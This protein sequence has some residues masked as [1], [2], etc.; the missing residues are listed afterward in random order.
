MTGSSLVGNQRLV[1]ITYQGYCDFGYLI[2]GIEEVN[3]LPM[4]RIEF[5]DTVQSYFP[6]SY[7]PKILHELGIDDFTCVPLKKIAIVY[8]SLKSS[9]SHMCHWSELIALH[10]SC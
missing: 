9:S 5:I 8:K 7:D 10:S 2:Q 3:V 6:R 4:S 1:W